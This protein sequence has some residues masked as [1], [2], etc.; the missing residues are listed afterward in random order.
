MSEQAAARE[1]I[2]IARARIPELRAWHP[3]WY[4]IEWVATLLDSLGITP[5][6]D[7]QRF[8][9]SL[10]GRL[11]MAAGLDTLSQTSVAHAMHLARAAENIRSAS[12]AADHDFRGNRKWTFHLRN[13]V[14]L[15][16]VASTGGAILRNL[17]GKCLVRQGR[18]QPHARRSAPARNA[19]GLSPCDE[20]GRQRGSTKHRLL[21]IRNISSTLSPSF[22]T[23]SRT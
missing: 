22:T 16:E 3:A 21:A 13:G 9:D 7:V 14:L 18:A 6:M 20:E 2:D 19:G 23:T 10:M 1:L 17:F 8:F 11:T 4:E 12:G 5:L 15:A